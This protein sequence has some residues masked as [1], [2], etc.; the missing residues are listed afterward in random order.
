[1]SALVRGQLLCFGRLDPWDDNDK[2]LRRENVE[3][4]EAG[5]SLKEFFAAIHWFEGRPPVRQPIDA[6]ELLR[7]TNLVLE[8]H[9]VVLEVELVGVGPGKKIGGVT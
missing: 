3:R 8:R 7:L 4:R 1:M 5:R 6:E 2:A 9:T